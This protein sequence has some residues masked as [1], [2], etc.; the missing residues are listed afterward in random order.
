MTDDD[1]GKLF[2]SSLPDEDP[3]EDGLAA[4]MAAAR[5]KAVELREAAAPPKSWWARFVETLQ[6][7]PALALATVIVL[8]G[9]AVI[10]KRHGELAA[11]ATAPAP[12][13]P[14]PVAPAPAAV[15]P[16]TP[17]PPSPAIANPEPAPAPAPA[18]TKPAPPPPPAAPKPAAAPAV[19]KESPRAEALDEAE[20]V[21]DRQYA[22]PPPVAPAPERRPTA[23]PAG[24]AIASDQTVAAPADGPSPDQLFHEC[25]TAATRGDCAAVKSIAG[26]IARTNA[27]LYR[28]RVVKDTSIAK[29]LGL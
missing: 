16:V 22:T 5:V 4:L 29:C 3:P 27:S 18:V 11:P 9:G 24:V 15:A 12:V 2:R 6:R 19:T 26:R 7:P 23:P 1:L 21:T 17:P 14:A 8:V 28:D 10:V 13:A 25:Q 20:D